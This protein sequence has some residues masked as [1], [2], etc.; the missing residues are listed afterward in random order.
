[1][2]EDDEER[3][4]R[5]LRK[6]AMGVELDSNDRWCLRA[7]ER[8]ERER[9][10]RETRAQPLDTV[11]VDDTSELFDA[12]GVLNRELVDAVGYALSETSNQLR[13]ESRAEIDKLQRT[14]DQLRIELAEQRG[15]VFAWRD[16]RPDKVVD[17]PKWRRNNNAA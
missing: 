15:E 7:Y 17:L 12:E 16:I 5:A 8:Y 1:M 11:V 4:D 10:E 2:T 13:E 3:I 14:I 9:R 6:Q